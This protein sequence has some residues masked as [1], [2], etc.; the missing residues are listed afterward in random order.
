MQTSIKKKVFE[1]IDPSHAMTMRV[2]T[3]MLVCWFLFL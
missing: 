1:L 3:L 2:K